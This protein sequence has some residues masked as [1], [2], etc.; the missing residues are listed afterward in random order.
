M[1]GV[2]RKSRLVFADGESCYHVVSRVAGRE[3]L[4][5]EAEKEAMLRM[6]KRQSW[7]SGVDVLAWC[8]MGNHFH[9][10]L[11]V[12]DKR[13]MTAGWTEDDSIGRL[14]RIGSEEYT[15][16]ILADVK[17]WR[18][19]GN[20]TGPRRVA[21]SVE[22]RLFDLSAFMKEFKQRFSVWYNAQ[23]GRVGTLWEERFRSVLVEGGGEL[24]AGGKLSMAEA[25]RFRVRHFTEGAAIGG[26]QFLES[27]FEGRR[28]WFGPRRKDGA[29]RIRGTG[30]DWGGVMSLRDLGGGKPSA[31]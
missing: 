13:R 26:R 9:L 24:G 27:V 15:K 12:P 30:A 19:E 10:L 21:E 22:A 8:F 5:G 2:K 7:F 16:G 4:F 28:A 11:R 23:H 20:T 29:R 14:R 17:R 18:K 25:L 1:G 31:G 6:M 3:L